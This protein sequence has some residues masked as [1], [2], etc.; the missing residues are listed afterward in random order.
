MF[1]R[2]YTMFTRSTRTQQKEVRKVWNKCDRL[3]NFSKKE[4]LDIYWNIADNVWDRRIG[5]KPINFD[6][7]PDNRK[8]F[9]KEC[10]SEILKP[11]ILKIEDMTTAKER[12][13]YLNVN[14]QKIQTKEEFQT[15]WK[16]FE[17]GK[18]TD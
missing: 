16:T 18:S 7:L 11:Y 15:F 12:K 5:R 8:K 14:I 13:E 10:K 4:L 9:K 3:K 17:L 2:D 1:P 6:S